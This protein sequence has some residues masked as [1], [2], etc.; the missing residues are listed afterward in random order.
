[1]RKSRDYRNNFSAGVVSKEHLAASR[2]EL[3]S[4]ALKTGTNAFLTNARTVMRRGGTVRKFRMPDAGR[5]YEFEMPDGT[6]RHLNFI[7][8]AVKIYQDD[9]TLESTEAGPWGEAD[10]FTMSIVNDDDRVFIFS[11]S[12]FPQTLAYSSSWTLGNFAFRVEANGHKA[13]PFIGSGLLGL[14]GVTM[15]PS[16]YLGSITLTFSAPVLQAGHAGYHFM[17]VRNQIRIDSVVSSTSATATVIDPLYP[18]VRVSV[19]GAS[20]YKVGDLAEGDITNTRGQIVAVG[21]GTVDIVLTEG[22][23]TFQS[24]TGDLAGERLI[25]GEASYE[26]TAQATLASPQATNIWFEEAISP[27]RGYPSTGALHR[28]RLC[29]AGFPAVPSLLACSSYGSVGDYDLGAASER[30]AI[31]EFIGEDPN[32][33]VKHLVST[34]QLVLLTDRGA[35]YVPEGGDRRFTPQGIGFDPISP[36]A[37]SDIPPVWTPEGVV[38]L[39]KEYRALVLGLTGTQRGAWAVTDIS[40]LGGELIKTPKQMVYSS[41]IGG[42]RERVIIILNSDGTAAVFTYRRGGEQAGWTPW[43]RRSTDKYLSFSSWNGEVYCLALADGNRTFEQF[44]F[45][46]VIDSEFDPAS[47][48]YASESVHMLLGS[49]VVGVNATDVGGDLG[50]YAEYASIDKIG[51]DFPVTIE[52]AALVVAQA[53]RQKRRVVKTWV[54]VI[55]SGTFRLNGLPCQGYLYNSDFEAPPVVS[56]REHKTGQ[57]GSSRDRTVTIEQRDG[58]GAPLHVRSITMR[59]SVR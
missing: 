52:P 37:S 59:V 7:A 4:Q 50:D 56:D 39:D 3:T 48:A 9:G 41:G 31:L 30:D 5:T 38:F 53:G 45:D 26:I 34:E 35:W 44:D 58:E 16:G 21:A 19:G 14:A 43:V 12:F 42:R 18:T 33:K 24:P 27:A 15:N 17:Y 47:T 29:M 32:A 6:L 46:A 23:S 57:L 11:N 40:Q 25:S 13:S 55:D 51:H 22:Y 20:N 10:L 8:G 1:M 28:T 49:H 36:D 54:D 2:E